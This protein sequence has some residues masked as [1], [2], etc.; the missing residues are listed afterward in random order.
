M[1]RFNRL[2]PTP[3]VSAA[4]LAT[5][6]VA[7]AVSAPLANPPSAASKPAR[8]TP[9]APANRTSRFAAPVEKVSAVQS[10]G[11]YI[12]LAYVFARFS[13]MSEILTFG[14]GFNIYLIVVV[15]SLA[16]FATAVTG[17]FRR[18]LLAPPAY[19]L[20]GF[21]LWLVATIP[22]STWRGGSFGLLKTSFMTDFSMFFMIVALTL[23]WRQCVLLMNAI[24]IGGAIDF[25]AT[26]IYGG[27]EDGRLIMSFGTL[28]NPNDLATHLL[29]ALPF[30]VLL[31]LNH[32]S[33]VVRPLAL[34]A[35]IAMLYA[36]I[37][38]GSR[39]ALLSVGVCVIYAFFRGTA[40]QKFGLAAGGALVILLT[41]AFQP[42][43]V[44]LRYASIFSNNVQVEAANATDY[45]YAVGSEAARKQ[46]LIDSIMTTLANPLFGVGPGNYASADADKKNGAGQTA[47]W[48]VTHNSYTQVSAESG[49][50]GFILF[51]GLII[52]TFT[53]VASTYRHTRKHPQ[54]RYIS[55]TAFILLLT[56]AGFGVNIFFSALAYTYYLPTLAAISIVVCT[57][58]KQELRRF[59]AS[60]VMSYSVPG[61]VRAPSMQMAVQRSALPT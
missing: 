9:A 21:M 46:L 33:M 26:R 34:A 43:S 4:A 17:G 16:A 41:L 51:A 24:A 29:I 6:A 35:A 1:S 11:F 19:F 13:L 2:P 44:L 60:N 23:T 7:A 58:A 20:V 47:T 39:A 61:S 30:C 3:R 49:V 57:L 50:P 55:N 48:Q 18:F 52:S 37:Q 28:G 22:F 8:E 15:G 56:L 45:E 31:L 42:A 32:K 40:T 38:T 54:L 12:I 25:I 53:M 27:S 10:L 36:I 14:L 59:E 5:T